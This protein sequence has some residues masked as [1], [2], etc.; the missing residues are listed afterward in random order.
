MNCRSRKQPEEE[1]RRKRKE[2]NIRHWKI[3]KIK[4]KTGE[5]DKTPKQLLKLPT[6]EKE[7]QKQ[8]N[9]ERK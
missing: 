6:Q 3:N 8:K 1:K 5:D 7:V 9:R 4:D 2:P